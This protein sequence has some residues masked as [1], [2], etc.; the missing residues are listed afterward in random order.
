LGEGSSCPG[1]GFVAQNVM[2]ISALYGLNKL[3]GV[4]KDTRRYWIEL[5]YLPSGTFCVDLKDSFVRLYGSTY[6]ENTQSVIVC[7]GSYVVYGDNS[8]SSAPININLPNF[9]YTGSGNILFGYTANLIRYS[10]DSFPM[11]RF[12]NVLPSAKQTTVLNDDVN[13]WCAAD[14]VNVG[15]TPGYPNQ[16][17]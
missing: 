2:H 1:S 13:N 7:P 4:E 14:S 16:E 3:V 12:G 9:K 15:L 11:N 17:C 6:F 5:R 10:L 8:K